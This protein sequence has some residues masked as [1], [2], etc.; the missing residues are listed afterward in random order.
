[1]FLL[2]NS[3]ISLYG[4]IGL[5]GI[6]TILELLLTMKLMSYCEELAKIDQSKKEA[7]EYNKSAEMNETTENMFA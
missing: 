4:S 1:M 2:P 6:M 3:A 7:I 5:V